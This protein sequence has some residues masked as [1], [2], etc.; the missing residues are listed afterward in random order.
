MCS[1]CREALRSAGQLRLIE[2]YYWSVFVIGIVPIIV[3]SVAFYYAYRAY[4]NQPL[5]PK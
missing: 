2:G 4:R 5:P 1:L 3:L